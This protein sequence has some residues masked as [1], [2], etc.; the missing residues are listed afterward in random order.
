MKMHVDEN[1]K[2]VPV[3]GIGGKGIVIDGTS[4]TAKSA[5][6]EAGVYRICP[7]EA[8]ADG[9]TYT[10]GADTV[11]APLEAKA[12]D[13]YLAVGAI[14]SIFVENGHKIAVLGG[15]LSVTPLA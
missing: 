9:V 11:E 12:T 10:V 13:T 5:A 8:T 6:L 14:E 4:A 15:K 3:L 1:G 2:P 7:S